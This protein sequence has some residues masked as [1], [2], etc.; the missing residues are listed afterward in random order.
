MENIPQVGGNHY[1]SFKIQPWE[2]IVKNNIGWSEG[3]VIKYVSRWRNKNGV[4]D[5]RK[6]KTVIENLIAETLQIEQQIPPKPTR[7]PIIDY[8]LTENEY[9]GL[10]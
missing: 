1:Q 3:E 7:Y 9:L 2:Y 8:Q 6:A 10:D 4:E 5:L